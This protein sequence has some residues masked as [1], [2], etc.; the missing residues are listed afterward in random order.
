MLVT[1][2]VEGNL[3]AFVESFFEIARYG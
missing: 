1:P 3:K 2:H